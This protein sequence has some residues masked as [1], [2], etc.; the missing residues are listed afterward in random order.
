MIKESPFSCFQISMAT[1]VK[2]AG[3]LMFCPEASCPPEPFLEDNV[4]FAF[5][6]RFL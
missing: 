2:A 3:V 6:G 5:R 4:N 1:R